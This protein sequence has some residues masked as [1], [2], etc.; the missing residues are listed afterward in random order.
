MDN[1]QSFDGTL[2]DR[3]GLNRHA[4]FNLDALPEDVIAQVRTSCASPRAY[5]QLILIGHAGRTLWD[6][7]TASGIRS[8]D[9][10]DDFSTQVVRQ[11][12]AQHHSCNEYE[13]LYPGA[14]AVG[15][16]RLGMLAGWHHA[17][18][19]MVGIDKSW[20]TWYAYRVLIVAD[21]RFAPTPPVQDEHPCQPCAHKV[22]ITSCPARAMDQGRFD[23]GKCV[24]YR[25]QDGS[26]CRTTCLARVSCPVGVEHRYCDAQIHHTYLGSM[27]AIERFY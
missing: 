18:P 8:D 25:K 15:L 21:T 22:C 16:Q 3:V 4:V 13:I 19:F 2:L 5:R 23:L 6:S 24:G 26:R 10:I 1:H 7:V 27:R 11:W 14:H 17:S 9:P 20:G 12:F